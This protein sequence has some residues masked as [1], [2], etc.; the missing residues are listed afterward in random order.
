MKQGVKVMLK[1]NIDFVVLLINSKSE[2]RAKS[3]SR[4]P[5]FIWKLIWLM[6]HKISQVWDNW[7][8]SKSEQSRLERTNIFFS[9]FFYRLLLMIDGTL[10]FKLFSV[11]VWLSTHFSVQKVWKQLTMISSA[12]R[13]FKKIQ[14][15]YKLLS[16][17]L[18]DKF[19]CNWAIWLNFDFLRSWFMLQKRTIQVVFFL[20]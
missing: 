5:Y 17:I 4:L 1:L 20:C 16:V 8:E 6:C 11:G 15:L 2:T 12:G 3:C 7:D 9:I 18:Q 10:E 14:F 19:F 13:F